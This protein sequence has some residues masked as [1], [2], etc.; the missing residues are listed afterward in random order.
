MQFR[1]QSMA[2]WEKLFPWEFFRNKFFH[3]EPS[4]ALRT[5]SKK[6][7]FEPFWNPVRMCT[8]ITSIGV[9]PRS[10]AISYSFFLFFLVA[11][12][13]RIYTHVQSD[14]DKRS[15]VQGRTRLLVINRRSLMVAKRFFANVPRAN[16]PCNWYRYEI[17]SIIDDLIYTWYR[18]IWRGQTWR[19][20]HG[21]RA[22]RYNICLI[23]NSAIID[24]YSTQRS[25]PS[26]PIYGFSVSS[27]TCA[28]RRRHEKR[29]RRRTFPLCFPLPRGKIFRFFH[30]SSL[31]GLEIFQ[32][33]VPRTDLRR[34]AFSARDLSCNAHEPAFSG[35]CWAA[36]FSL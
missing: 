22:A 21:N 17:A 16:L 5:A 4:A 31:M 28:N 33:R 1:T 3:R 15:F 8:F 36:D 7:V 11:S 20:F 34:R 12:Q 23:D 25:L 2:Y 35:R 9:L 10:S 18:V 29:F 27:V 6:M 30:F 26:L 32:I 14:G 19:H 13:S 24:F